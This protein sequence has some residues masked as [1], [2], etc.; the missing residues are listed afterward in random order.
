MKLLLTVLLLGTCTAVVCL[1]QSDTTTPDQPFTIAISAARPTFKTTQAV[2][3]RIRLT[4]TSNHPIN[5]T[6]VW[7]RG[8]GVN[9]SYAY[10]IRDASGRVAEF[11]PEIKA[12]RERERQIR[13]VIIGTLN[14][15]EAAEAISNLSGC[16]DMSAPGEYSIQL[17]RAIAED[18]KQPAVKSNKI[19]ITVAPGEGQQ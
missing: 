2:E 17:S 18:P 11:L 10:D 14:P 3:I 7:M 1:T 9:Q 15:G 6:Q 19:T 12:K 16:Y 5:S 13:T 8:C 4:N